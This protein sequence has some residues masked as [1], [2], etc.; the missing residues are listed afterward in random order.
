MIAIFIFLIIVTCW[1]LNKTDDIA[2]DI[3][4]RNSAKEK[5]DAWY[6]DHDGKKR[7]TDNNKHVYVDNGSIFDERTYEI[8]YDKVE[9]LT[10]EANKECT[11]K[12]LNCYVKLIKINEY[13]FKA[14]DH[15][16]RMA[17][18]I[19]KSTGKPFWLTWNGSGFYKY[20]FKSDDIP[21]CKVVFKKAIVRFEPDIGKAKANKIDYELYKKFDIIYTVQRINN[22]ISSTGL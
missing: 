6:Y 15:K 19:D 5:G 13:S 21:V 8:L 7:L 14:K 16:Y 9:E 22:L 17:V 10:K 12:G 11:A 20:D 4:S 3:R 1:L 18:P 2:R